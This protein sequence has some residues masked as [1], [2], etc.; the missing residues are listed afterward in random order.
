MMDCVCIGTLEATLQQ[1]HNETL[2]SL[3]ATSQPPNIL[4]SPH[5]HLHTQIQ[6]RQVGLICCIGQ[7]QSCTLSCGNWSR[8]ISILRLSCLC[9]IYLRCWTLRFSSCSLP[10]VFS[11]FLQFHQ[12]ITEITQTLWEPWM[13]SH[14][15]PSQTVLMRNWWQSHF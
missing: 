5:P 8:M 13:G 7:C 10:P 11:V 6:C 9:Y 3:P 15:T 4:P 2:I 12:I 1:A 14:F